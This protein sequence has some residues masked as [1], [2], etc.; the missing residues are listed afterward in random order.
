MTFIKTLD[1]C[2]VA[3]NENYQLCKW[4]GDGNIV[5]SYA[6]RGKAI[7][8]NFSS[9]KK[10]LRHIKTAINE[11]C[12]TV[13]NQYEWCKMIFAMINKDSVVRLVKKCGFVKLL[14]FCHGVI[15]VRLR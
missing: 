3:H 15:Y 12:C 5:F 2:N 8:A 7:N 4:K 9:D 11:F 1:P 13:F 10:G 6:K 14:D